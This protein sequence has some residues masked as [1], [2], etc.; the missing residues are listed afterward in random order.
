MKAY[1]AYK[2]SGVEWLGDIPEGWDV[3]PLKR[4]FGVRLGKMLQPAS[5]GDS[6][7]E[8]PYLRAAN[9]QWSGLQ[10]ADVKS[11]WFSPAETASLELLK[12]DLLVSEGGDVGRSSVCDRDLNG[13]YFQNSINRV[14]ALTSHSTRF[15]FYWISSVKTAG[16]I[17]ILCNK[18]TIAHFTAEKVGSL[19]TPFPPPHEQCAIAAFLDREVAK[20]DGL[21]EEQRRLI[22]LL[23]EKRQATISHAVT[24]GLNPN[25]KLKPSGIDWLGDVPEGWNVV[26]LKDCTASG[27]GIQMGPFGGMLKDLLPVEDE[28]KVYG[29]EN[30]TNKDVNR[31]ARWIDRAR[32]NE[33]SNYSLFCGDLMLTRKGTVGNCFRFPEGAQP[34]IIDSDTIRIRLNG[35]LLDTD[36]ALTTL[37]SAHYI[38][39]QIDLTKRGAILSGLNTSVVSNLLVLLPP[40]WEQKE[41]VGLLSVITHKLETVEAEANAL[42]SLLLERR[43]A[44]IS[45]AVTGKIDV[46]DVAPDMMEPA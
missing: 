46:R 7:F 33:L 15:L 28:Y 19:P 44:L 22:A 24:K 5:K 2:P 45:A 30:V 9:L 20:I 37:H 21:I 4:H 13:I 32:Y 36:Y 10:L 34:G 29:Q 12:G 3:G 42:V 41:I 43:S 35:D 14:R 25:A 8:A 40:L 16:Y 18:S 31:G 26:R 17:D 39:T 23:A 1:P 38:S 27:D 11:M 6:D